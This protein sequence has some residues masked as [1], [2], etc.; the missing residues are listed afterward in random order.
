M[1]KAVSPTPAISIIMPLYNKA[2]QVLD[3]VASVAAQTVSDWELVIVDDGSTDDG[4]AL[5]RALGDARIRMV[6][7]TN[8]GV[9]A[10]RNRGVELARADLVTFLDADDLWF[11]EFLATVGLQPA[12]QFAPR[13]AQRL[14]PGCVVRQKHSAGAS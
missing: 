1:V 4:P 10:A 6:S 2:A 11:P 14:Q 12:M 5:V 13:K 3:T 8:A 9:S 7:Q